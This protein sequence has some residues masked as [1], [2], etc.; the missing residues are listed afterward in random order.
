[1]HELGIAEELASIVLRE[2]EKG[3]LTK[4]SRV[5]ICFGELVQIVPDIFRFAFAETVKDTIAQ[6]TEIDLEITKIKM[7]CSV[8]GNEFQVTDSDFKCND[9]NSY[10]LEFV[11]GNEV[12]VKS[13]EGD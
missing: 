12:F 13:I 3:G 1:M 2:A 9:C 11:N 5:S 8:C 4:V 10:E 6:E 7:K